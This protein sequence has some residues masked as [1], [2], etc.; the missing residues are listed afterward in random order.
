MLGA[1]EAS[2]STF[3]KFG[4]IFLH[5]Y[6][7]LLNRSSDFAC[8]DRSDQK[9][10]L[11]DIVLKDQK[12]NISELVNKISRIKCSMQDE[13]EDVEIKNIKDIFAG[14]QRELIAMNG[15][16]FDD[17][18][19]LPTKILKDNNEL[20]KSLPYSYIM[21]DEYQDTDKSQRELLKQLC[22]FHNNICVVG[23]DDQTIYSFR[24]ANHENI[25]DFSK[26]FAGA[27]TIK[28]EQNYRSTMNILKASNLLILNNQKRLGK[29]LFSELGEGSCVE[30]HELPTPKQEAQ[31]ILKQVRLLISKGHAADDIAILYRTNRQS[32]ALEEVFLKNDQPYRIKK[33]LPFYERAEVKDVLSYMQLAINQ[34]NDL[35]FKRACNQPRR[36]FGEKKLQALG[37]LAKAKSCSLFA[38]LELSAKSAQE[39]SFLSFIKSL[40]NSS[41]P[42]ICS[43]IEA[44]NLHDC[45]K[46]DNQERANNIKE[47]HKALQERYKEG[48]DLAQALSEIALYS[49]SSH[50]ENEGRGTWF[51][52]VHASKGLEFGAVFVIGMEA[53]LF[54]LAGSALEEE[55]RLA[56]VA[57][58]RAKRKLTLSW[59]RHKDFAQSSPS[60]FLGELQGE[61]LEVITGP[62]EPGELVRHK[63]FGIGRVE[64]RVRGSMLKIVFSG[65]P[66][67]IDESFLERA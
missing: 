30:F 55:R 52:S 36:G 63:L 29:T 48:Q 8:V 31:F 10:I 6:I 25:L 11:K 12:I 42:V 1:N 62:L 4:I 9:R 33:G 14:Y 38:A 26:D 47:L 7:H 51:M 61:V 28:L 16:D 64:A 27:K 59:S 37:Q 50:S 21:V 44:L 32:R 65:Q 13:I 66:R 60:P 41:T 45:Y 57:C 40:S 53:G 67:V 2:L 23:D 5:K 56:Y 43:K 18:I 54:P 17:M 22:A 19:L 34:D 15:I 49:H 58:T 35:A 46:D 24:G 39:L 20:A 3:H